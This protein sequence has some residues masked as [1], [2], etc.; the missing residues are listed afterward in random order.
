MVF[1]LEIVKRK[2]R[3]EC[4]PIYSSHAGV[5]ATTWL[6]AIHQPKAKRKFFLFFFFLDS[7]MPKK[8]EPQPKTSC[9]VFIIVRCYNTDGELDFFAEFLHSCPEYR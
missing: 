9:S 4:R 2:K 1:L 5:M 3:E 6:I 8:S 7:L